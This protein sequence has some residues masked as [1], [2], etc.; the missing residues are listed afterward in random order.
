M[1][2]YSEQG[3]I[4]KRLQQSLANQ[5][6]AF[7]GQQRGKRR[8]GDIERQY[9]EGY[10]PL[11]AS[12]GRRGLGG[13]S[14]ESG[15]MRGGLSRYAES[16]QRDLG[17]ETQN[18]QDELNEIAMTEAA[19]QAD[20]EDYLTALRLQQQADILSSAQTLKSLGAY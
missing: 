10:Q 8:M 12:Y 5:Q 11:L 14:V 9:Q 6:A 16:L 13:P 2:M 18:M 3:A 15:I 17:S 1:A 20:L 7:L 4:R 19:Q